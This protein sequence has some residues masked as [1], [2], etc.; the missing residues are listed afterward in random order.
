KWACNQLKVTHLF[1]FNA[2]F[3]Y[4]PFP[5]PFPPLL[6]LFLSSSFPLPS[7]PFSFFSFFFSF[8]SSSSPLSPSSPFSPFFSSLL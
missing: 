4:L 2:R 6:F 1:T 7:L 5:S 3:P 8:F